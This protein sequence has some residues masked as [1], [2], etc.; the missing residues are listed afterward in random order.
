M[1]ERSGIESALDTVDDLKREISEYCDDARSNMLLPL[2]DQT[3]SS[4]SQGLGAVTKVIGASM[5]QLLT[6]ATQVHGEC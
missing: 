2:P 6:A 5:A 1:C 3:M 4:C